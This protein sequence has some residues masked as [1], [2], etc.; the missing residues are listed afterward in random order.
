[1]TRASDL[2]RAYSLL[3]LLG[4]YARP[5]PPETSYALMTA[6]NLVSEWHIPDTLVHTDEN[7]ELG[8]LLAQA[9]ELLTILAGTA[10]DLG[11]ALSL[12]RAAALLDSLTP[13]PSDHR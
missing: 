3:V 12:G 5:I 1:M 8:D 11:E 2:D 9:T 6:F 7:A 10:T 13:E 4:E